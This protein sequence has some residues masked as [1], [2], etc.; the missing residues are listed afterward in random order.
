MCIVE[1]AAL[2]DNVNTCG[3]LEGGTGNAPST[4]F[5]EDFIVCYNGEPYGEPVRCPAGLRFDSK[6]MRCALAS[7]ASCYPGTINSAHLLLAPNAPIP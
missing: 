6:H 7:D 5:C 1:E 3:K 4:R 2:C